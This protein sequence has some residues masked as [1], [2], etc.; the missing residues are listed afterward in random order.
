MMQLQR[1]QPPSGLAPD[2]SGLGTSL[3]GPDAPPSPGIHNT[4]GFGTSPVAGGSNGAGNGMRTR[5]AAMEPPRARIEPPRIIAPP[6]MAE[7]PA[8]P[9]SPLAPRRSPRL[10]RGSPPRA[11]IEPPRTR[12]VTLR[13]NPDVGFGVDV[14]TQ[15]EGVNVFRHAIS[16]V[17]PNSPAGWQD[18]LQPGDLVVAL[19]GRSTRTMCGK[20]LRCLMALADELAMEVQP[21]P[22]Q[23]RPAL[24]APKFAAFSPSVRELLEGT[25]KPPPKPTSRL[26]TLH[27]AG[28]G[29]GFCI[30]PGAN[31][32]G[33]RVAALL[34]G[35]P[36]ELSG[37][38]C[39]G[40]AILSVNSIKITSMPHHET[41]LAFTMF[42]TAT[43]VLK[44][45]DTPLRY[46]GLI[47]QPQPP[48]QP[49][50]KTA[51]PQPVYKR[52]LVRV[53]AGRA[54]GIAVAAADTG[55]GASV[56][57]VLPDSA[58]AE[59][60][61]LAAG[62]RILEV[63]GKSLENLPPAAVTS[64]LETAVAASAVLLTLLPAAAAADKENKLLDRRDP[65]DGEP[66]D[67]PGI[68]HML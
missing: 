3:R 62:D 67:A 38:V 41:I 24:P 50:K 61:L 1:R 36:A 15:S 58:A 35:G 59:A 54:L 49:P 2:D 13:R 8:A 45:D 51:K 30:V 11:V 63:N 14:A 47:V 31:G 66:K 65:K 43:L 34:S 19:N 17:V 18:R 32:L 29:F 64:M 60:G 53:P 22:L 20:E 23:P 7:Q 42:K 46:S 16:A 27:N 25:A 37:D 57:R 48:A 44:T 21:A 33:A 40:D 55:R 10:Q 28:H 6:C 39:V 56:L 52:V 5:A 26:V 12:T 9:H 68:S 4:T